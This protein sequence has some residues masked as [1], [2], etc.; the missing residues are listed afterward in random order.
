M[1]CPRCGFDNPS[2]TRFCGQCGTALH[3]PCPAC[4]ALNPPGFAFCGACGA[5]L[6]PSPAAPAPTPA[7]SHAESRDERRVVTILFA[8]VTGSTALAERLDAEQIRTIMARFF[9]AMTKEVVR[10]EGTV[11]KF[12]GD[13]VMAVFGL[14]SI[15]EDDAERAVRAALAMHARLGQLSAE[16]EPSWGITLQMRVGINTGEVVANPHATLRGEFMVTGDAVNV[17]ARLRSAAGPGATVVGERTYRDTAGVA[18]YRPLPSIAVKGKAAPLRAWELAGILHAPRRRGFGGLHAPMVGREEELKLLHGLL[19]R[20]IRERSPYLVSIIGM[21]G[22]GK[23][24]LLA[25]FQAGLPTSVIL[26]QDRS[27]SYGSTALWS[28]GEIVRADAGIL[29]EDPLPVIAEK[30]EHRLDRLLGEARDQREGRQLRA[31]LARVLAIPSLDG[32]T[33]HDG[34]RE[35]LFWALRRYFERLAAQGPLI[36]G[37]EDLHWGDAELL[38]FIEY[39]ARWAS[40]VPIL[41]LCLARPE[42]LETRPGWGGGKRNYSSLFLDRLPPDDTERLVRELLRTDGLPA[43]LSQAVGVAEGNPFFVEEILRMLIDAGA[44]RRDADR[45]QVTG[46]LTSAVPDTIQ[47]VLAARLDRLRPDERTAIQQASIIGKVFWTGALAH[48]AGFTE[49]TLAP[50]LGALQSKDLVLQHEQSALEGEREFSFSHILIRDVAYAMLPKATRCDK[51]RLFAAWLERT[52]GDRGEEYAEILAYHWLQAARLGREVGL[53]GGWALDAPKALGYSLAAGRRAARVYAGDQARTHFETA[54]ALATELGADPQ[55]I[56]AVEGLADMHALQAQ[57]ER[58]SQLYQEALD[59]HLQ[60]GDAVQQA[61]VQSRIGST[62]SGVFDFRQALPH[63]QSAMEALKGET[64]PLELA[65]VYLQMARTQTALGHFKEAEEFGRLGLRAAEEHDLQVLVSEGNH[66]LGF[67]STLLGRPDAAGYYAKSIE[68]AE[69]QNDPGQVGHSYRYKSFYHRAW[70]EYPEAVHALTRA[71]A[72]ARETNNRPRIAHGLYSLGHVHFVT[73][74]WKA[75]TSFL[76]EYLAMSEEIPTWVEYARSILAFLGGGLPEALGLAH[77]AI[78]HA[79]HRRDLPNLGFTLDWCAF[80]H[81]RLNQPAECRQLLTDALAR[82]VPVGVFWPAYLHPL[83]AE[84]ALALG[85]GEG[86]A[87]HCRQAT[88]KDWVEIKPA[89]ARLL[90]V[91][92]LL[93]IAQQRRD[94]GQ[95]LIREAADLYRAIGQPYDRALCLEALAGALKRGGRA[96]EQGRAEE[97]LRDAVEI[98][99]QLGAEFEVRRLHGPSGASEAGP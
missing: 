4:G 20:V 85:D 90:K 57:W 86:A 16:V 31:H 69:R 99:R 66:I 59:Y 62:F 3:A 92:G 81:L 44:L 80:L 72:L 63:I 75:A 68:I 25:E 82:L 5:S 60:K 43:G 76:R 26:R 22:V 91:R 14:P 97:A 70:G 47:G 40:G 30:L 9:D 46:V 74:D 58:A 13:E 19:H 78:A 49:P 65:G 55:R 54:R 32:E 96:D 10:H 61:R 84:A 53:P 71:L 2:G 98:Y 24:R 45:W 42:L 50:I 21:P 1:H 12:I 38:D 7:A 6:N 17:A 88:R 51:H 95:A 15:H 79:E 87:E 36:L 33:A 41:I 8:D 11:E 93:G 89:Q 77:G 39:L 64:H 27:L 23:T 52:V 28:V 73:G 48:I 83:A 56:A 37:F 35:N 67:L 94:E 29:L 34:S 18:E